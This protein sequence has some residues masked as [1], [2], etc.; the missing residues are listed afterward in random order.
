MGG[1]CGG[2]LHAAIWHSHGLW[3]TRMQPFLP[4]ANPTSAT[5]RAGSS[6]SRWTGKA[7]PALRMALQTREQ[8]IKR[9][10]ATSNI[11]TAQALLASMAGMYAVYH[12]PEGLKAIA[13]RHPCPAGALAAKLTALGYRQENDRLF[14]YAAD[15]PARRHDG[16]RM[17]E[18]PGAGK[19]DQLPVLSRRTG[20]HQP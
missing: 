3:R 19:A 18:M 9:E 7:E 16:W 20:G 8:H 1:R 2:G 5:C 13:R 15:Y 4:H 10:R 12:G 11:C 14:R 6:A 17:Y